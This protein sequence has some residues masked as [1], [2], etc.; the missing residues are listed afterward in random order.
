MPVFNYGAGFQSNPLDAYNEMAGIRHK[1]KLQKLLGDAYNAPVEQRQSALASLLAFDADAGRKVQSDFDARDKMEAEKLGESGRLI[2]GLYRNQNNAQAQTAYM[3]VRDALQRKLGFPLP[4]E[5]DAGTA[6]ILGRL[7]SG[8]KAANPYDGLPADIQSLQ[9]LQDNPQLAALD[10]ERR[11]AS[12]MVPKLVQTSQGIGWGT[13]G[14]GIDLAPLNGVA[15]QGSGANAPAGELFAA[16]G[17]K[18]GIRPTSVQRSPSHNREVG[19]VP[20][21]YHLSGQAADWQVPPQLKQ[22]FVADAQANGFEAIDEGDHIHIEPAGRRGGQ[23]TI[24]QPY[25]KPE[26]ITPYQQAQLQL[27]RE[28]MDAKSTM[29]PF[30][31]AQLQMKAGKAK[32]ALSGTVADL[33][34]MASAVQKVL[35]APGLGRITGVMGAIPDIPGSDAANA[36]ADLEALKSQIGFAVLQK[37]RSM[38]PTGGALGNVSDAEGRRLE[39]NLASLDTAQSE[40]QLRQRL[41]DILDYIQSSKS[42]LSDAYSEQFGGMQQPQRPA[43]S[44]GQRVR[45]FNPATGRLE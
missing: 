22:Q 44:G 1:S 40:S 45:K 35:R 9:L 32:S 26:T 31:Q 12:G 19:G 3:N 21:S 16:L 37:M 13:P 10:R 27:E 15:G 7:G 36:R 11:Q 34:R 39:A 20:N 5:L 43:A 23:Q 4:Q 41:N 28:K 38:S 42:N 8:G 33:D 25:V 30:Q 29:T 24:A 2:S 6:D 17:Q 14:A 18:Y